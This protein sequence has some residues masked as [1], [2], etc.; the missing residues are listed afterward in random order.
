[1]LWLSLFG[2]Q[3]VEEVDI[4]KEIEILKTHVLLL[5]EL[6]KITLNGVLSH[7][8]VS[9]VLQHDGVVASDG[10]LSNLTVF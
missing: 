7:L 6:H 3:D 8:T 10:V 4:F 9:E 2:R 5:L 1:M